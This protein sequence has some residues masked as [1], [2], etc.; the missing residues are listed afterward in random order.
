MARIS[1]GRYQKKLIF[2]S[3]EDIVNVDLL[4]KGEP[5][6]GLRVNNEDTLLV[7]APDGSSSTV[8]SSDIVIALE[9]LY[10]QR[11]LLLKD[12]DVETLKYYDRIH[13]V[14]DALK[15]TTASH[16]KFLDI[17]LTVYTDER[18]AQPLREL[19]VGARIFGYFAQSPVGWTGD[20][21]CSPIANCAHIRRR[22]GA[23]NCEIPSF[24]V[25][26]GKLYTCS[27]QIPGIDAPKADKAV[28]S[29]HVTPNIADPK[30]VT[31]ILRQLAELGIKEVKV[32][33]H[34]SDGSYTQITDFVPI[35]SLYS[36]YSTVSNTII[37][38]GFIGLILL[39]ALILW[40]IFRKQN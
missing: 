36:T 9:K 37:I 27:N 2:P 34:N 12:L 18:R 32:V 21:I 22:G 33:R 30:I 6:F 11:N 20:P 28:V 31:P 5:Y 4:A 35:T 23:Y 14:Y 3:T 1:R 39:I 26:D 15:N 38:F 29:I 40:L 16:Q 7:K 10:Q 24:S 19:T 8:K 13:L 17:F 25:V